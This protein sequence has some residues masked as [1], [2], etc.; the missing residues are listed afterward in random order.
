MPNKQI[1]EQQAIINELREQIASPEDEAYVNQLQQ[2]YEDARARVMRPGSVA[3]QMIDH[4]GTVMTPKDQQDL[5][6]NGPN[7]G[8]YKGGHR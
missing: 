4:D 1:P 8:T 5:K 2:E 6:E 7:E 3:L